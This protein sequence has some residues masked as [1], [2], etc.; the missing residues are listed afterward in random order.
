MNGPLVTSNQIGRFFQIFVAF[1]E[2]LNSYT[3]LTLM[4][5][6]LLFRIRPGKVSFLASI[7]GSKLGQVKSYRLKSLY[8]TDLTY[9][10]QQS[11]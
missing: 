4:F 10:E 2:Y 8:I 1:S 7:S 11:G 9:L 5:I 6:A 3:V